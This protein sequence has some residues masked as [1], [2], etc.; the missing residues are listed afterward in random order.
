MA[1]PATDPAALCEPG[2]ERIDWRGLPIDCSACAHA[3]LTAAGRCE[4]GRACVED[5]YARRID[6]FFDW[7]PHLANRHVRHPHFEVRAIAARLANPFLLT[8]LLTD[9]EEAVRWNAVRRL[10]RR[11]MRMLRDDPHREVRIRVAGAL[12]ADDLAPMLADPDYYVRLVVA[13]RIAPALLQN[14]QADPEAEV[15]LVVATRL[16]APMLMA[17]AGDADA[18]VRLQVAQRL[19]PTALATMQHDPDWSVR[20]A[21]A[22]RCDD[23]AILARLAEDGD[24]LVRETAGRRLDGDP[25]PTS[26]A[27]A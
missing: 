23:R 27:M 7:N 5:R 15:R 26:G 17:M 4:P 22:S 8:A 10:P 16:P 12:D 9:A 21:V 19:A 25:D 20:H 11:Y 14:I 6:R 1:E 13:R 24:P 18:R 2:D 3:A